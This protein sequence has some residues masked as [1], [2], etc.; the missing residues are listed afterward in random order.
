DALASGVAYVT[1]DRKHAGV[2]AELGVGDN[3]TMT[4][5]AMFARFGVLDRRRERDAAEAGARS[6]GVRSAGLAQLAGTLSGGN[7]QK[8]LLAR[9]LLEKRKLLVLDEPTRGVD[10]GAKAEIYALVGRLTR[11]GLAVLF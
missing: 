4:S 2:F 10:V 5:L 9:F 1:E 8:T 6:F 7:Q 11:D 3:V